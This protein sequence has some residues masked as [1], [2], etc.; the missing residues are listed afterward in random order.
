MLE[1]KV[2]ITAQLAGARVLCC[3]GC[4]VNMLGSAPSA[5]ASVT[6]VSGERCPPI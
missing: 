2:G 1:I 5:P 6:G 3:A 4:P